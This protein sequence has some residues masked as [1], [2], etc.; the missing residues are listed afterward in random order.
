MVPQAP[1][2]AADYERMGGSVETLRIPIYWYECEPAPGEYDFS[3]LDEEIG[4]AARHGIRV[5]PFVYGT[6]YWLASE[7]PLAPRTAAERADWAAFLGQL[8]DRYGPGGS[9]WRGAPR[10]EPIRRWQ[11]WNEPNFLQFWRP[12]PEPR[13]YAKLLAASA[14][15]IRAGDPAA[16]VVLAGV[17]PVGAGMKTWVFLRKLYRVPGVKRDFDLAA[18]HPYSANI[19]ELDYQVERVRQVMEAA[20][21]GGTPLLISEVGVAS[22]GDHLSAFVL[23]PGGQAAYLRAAYS[24]LLALRHRWRIAGIDWF[25]WR[26]EASGD[27][28]CSFCQGA[29]LLDPSGKP[30]PAWVAF[31]RA[32]ATARVR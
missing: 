27:P 15:A 18:L 9:F 2:G 25:T 24:R 7:P 8:V 1:L 21:D 13:T 5:A 6:P 10:S 29:G 23:G 31:R 12:R 30:K 22:V 4:A 19:P 3:A 28:Y 26:D 14:R 32:V 20:G 17:A 16:Q 11:I